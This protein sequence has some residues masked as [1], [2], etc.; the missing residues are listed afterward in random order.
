MRRL[1]S[2]LWIIALRASIYA[3]IHT[4]CFLVSLKEVLEDLHDSIKSCSLS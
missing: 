4:T 2:P 3:A 1:S